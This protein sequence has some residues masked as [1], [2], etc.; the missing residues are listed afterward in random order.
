MVFAENPN[1]K[2]LFCLIKYARKI[3]PKNLRQM[4]KKLITVLLVE[5]K[6]GDARLIS[7]CLKNQQII[8]LNL[9]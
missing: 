2:N 1:A 6:L 7:E 8:S 5:D 4:K 9:K 3:S